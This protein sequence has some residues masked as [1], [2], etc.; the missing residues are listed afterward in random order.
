MKIGVNLWIWESPFRT[1]RHMDLFRKAKSLGAEVV[2]FA[3]EDDAVVDTGPV[4]RAL[5]DEGLAC[6]VIG[7]FGPSRDLSSENSE[8][9]RIG[10]DYARRC[11]DIT[12]EAGA[13]LYSGAVVGVGGDAPLSPA[14]RRSRLQ[15]AAECLREL[16]E[17]AAQAGVTVLHR[18]VE[19]R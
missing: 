10:R 1:D 16:G 3:I 9:R 5:Q 19:P 11:L 18:S 17:S 2:E 8:V 13:T 4:R 7:L 15:W 6:S 12:T 14:Q